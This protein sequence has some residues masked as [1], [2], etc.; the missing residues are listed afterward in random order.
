MKATHKPNISLVQ[1]EPRIVSIDNDLLTLCCC[2]SAFCMRRLL[3]N[4]SG[5]RSWL[6]FARSSS[7]VYA[8][9][10]I[11]PVCQH[12]RLFEQYNLWLC[13]VPC[14]SLCPCFTSY[15]WSIQPCPV[16]RISPSR[17]WQEK[18][19]STCTLVAKENSHF[20]TSLPL[21]WL[22]HRPLNSSYVSSKKLDRLQWTHRN[23]RKWQYPRRWQKPSTVR[24][25]KRG[26]WL[27]K[28]FDHLFTSFPSRWLEAT[29]PQGSAECS[30]L[31]VMGGCKDRRIGSGPDQRWQSTWRPILWVQIA[32]D[33]LSCQS[34][35][36]P[37]GSIE[38]VR[39][40]PPLNH[41]K[42]SIFSK[43]RYQPTPI[44][45]G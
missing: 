2:R 31:A 7:I 36:V 28:H 33:R 13:V 30:C 37:K 34:Y 14:T 39:L 25:R 19:G 3:L 1:S 35:R 17:I 22:N 26:P 45:I 4:I 23:T 38:L 32:A 10:W 29:V 18:F 43:K 16:H 8:R 15:L 40:F 5:C 12:V 27:A 24:S 44:E 6:Q 42:E 41:W 21:A 9:V 20:N 11:Q